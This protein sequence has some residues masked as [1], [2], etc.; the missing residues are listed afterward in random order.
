[1]K[2]VIDKNIPYIKG[3]L[4]PFAD[5]RYIKGNC[6]GKN[7]VLD[8]DGLIIRTRTRVGPDL[9]AGSS[10]KYVGTTTIGTD[11][12]DTEWCDN[13]GI[14]C[15]AAPGCNSGSVKQYILAALCTLSSKFKFIPKETTLGIIGVGNVGSKVAASAQVLGYKLIL[16]DPPRA[17]IEGD[18]DFVSLNRLI[19]NSDIISL[20]VPFTA[21]EPDPTQNLINSEN[22]NKMKSHAII[23]NTSR[24]GIVNEKILLNG[25]RKNKI[26][27]CVIDT[28]KQ[29]P[30]INQALMER[31]A[32]A[33][34]HIAGYS[35]DG[36]LRATSIILND[37]SDFFSLPEIRPN[38]SLA[39]PLNDIISPDISTDLN[40]MI[41]STILKT[42]PIMDDHHS[43]VNNPEKFE[44]L[45]NKYPARREFDSYRIK[46]APPE[47]EKILKKLGFN[48]YSD[49]FSA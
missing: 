48:I 49:G 27:A 12:I 30:A 36:K 44:E 4:E 5:I 8:A 45:R 41:G 21:G 42:Y 28:W 26:K 35:S 34:P 31:A 24:G 43:L 14:R 29:E 9:L 3:I 13:N 1:M 15:T 40:T 37:L 33:T 38:I 16:N 17:R 18:G 22:I 47:A 11:H 2:L 6:I 46:E 7:D 19:E 25:L 39:P 20:H 23:I 10:V 32:I